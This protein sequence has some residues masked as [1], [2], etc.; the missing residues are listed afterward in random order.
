MPEQSDY[1]R[2][3]AEIEKEIRS[4]RREPGSKLPSLSELREIHGVSDTVLKYAMTWLEAR[5]LIY[6]KQGKGIFVATKDR[7][8]TRPRA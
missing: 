3:S 5:G 7:W 8:W 6:R 2:I 4:G 1:S